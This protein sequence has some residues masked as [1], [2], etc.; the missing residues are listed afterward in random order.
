MSDQTARATKV[1]S[2]PALDDLG[3]ADNL[4]RSVLQ[5]MTKVHQLVSFAV[6]LIR[7]DVLLARDR[8]LPGGDLVKLLCKGVFS[9]SEVEA[10]VGLRR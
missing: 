6:Q 5:R 1:K 3:L 7:I 10:H 8:L 9:L 2:S 4:D